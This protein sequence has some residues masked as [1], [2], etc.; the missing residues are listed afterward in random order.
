M[1]RCPL[2]MG[3]CFLC[4]SSLLTVLF[5]ALCS[6]KRARKPKAP[7]K[8][9]MAM[10]LEYDSDSEAG[11]EA[12]SFLI[13]EAKPAAPSK[14]PTIIALTIT[15]IDEG[16]LSELAEVLGKH[17]E[18]LQGLF[19]RGD[20]EARPSFSGDGMMGLCLALAGSELRWVVF[21]TF[22]VSDQTTPMEVL[23]QTSSL[24][25]LRLRNCK[26]L[27][28]RLFDRAL[29]AGS[30]LQLLELHA[31]EFARTSEAFSFLQ[32]LSSFT[33]TPCKLRSFFND[34]AF[35]THAE[36]LLTS[37]HSNTSLTDATIRISYD[38]IHHVNWWDYGY[39]IEN[40]FAKVCL[41]NR[42]DKLLENLQLNAAYTDVCIDTPAPAQH[43][44]QLQQ[45]V[46]LLAHNPY[47]RSLR[48]TEAITLSASEVR[49]VS[50]MLQRNRSLTELYLRPALRDSEQR[51][52]TLTLL[53][54]LVPLQ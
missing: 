5:A 36:S 3:D 8:D 39:R 43:E 21:D 16:E 25:E 52:A 48:I 33:L 1:N 30:S 42:W 15:H 26:G 7:A 40:I 13:T 18:Q 29:N 2:R 23:L 6:G 27:D 54:A 9:V 22:Y 45:V 50:T 34:R 24:R 49:A 10:L 53:V 31:C 35:C 11:S 47:V 32:S 51:Q 37:V 28:C 44:K 20:A 46:E 19:L 12:N 38:D 4:C 14:K 17:T 41:R